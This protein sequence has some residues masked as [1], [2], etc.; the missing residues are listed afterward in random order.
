MIAR[1]TLGM[2]YSSYTENVP[3]L[4]LTIS[5]IKSEIMVR[6]FSEK[7]SKI[8]SLNASI[9]LLFYTGGSSFIF[10]EKFVLN[11]GKNR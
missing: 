10:L 9:Y 1:K 2:L 8:V 6:S 5:N 11:S 4:N 7:L 3:K